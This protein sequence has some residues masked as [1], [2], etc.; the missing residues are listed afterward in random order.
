[1]KCLARSTPSS[2]SC[3][4]L[5]RRVRGRNYSFMTFRE[6]GEVIEKKPKIARFE[7]GKKLLNDDLLVI[8]QIEP[9]V[10]VGQVQLQQN[11]VELFGGCVAALERLANE[12]V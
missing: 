9:N 6:G 8:L 5:H 3:G 10:V 4:R 1:M 2:T 12:A 7:P 11:P